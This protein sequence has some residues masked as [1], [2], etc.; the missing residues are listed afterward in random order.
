[1]AE[2]LAIPPETVKVHR[3]HRY[4]KLDI[5]AQPE[6]FSLFLQSLGHAPPPL[7]RPS[8]ATMARHSRSVRTAE[9]RARTLAGAGAA[10]RLQAVPSNTHKRTAR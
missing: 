8:A 7:T 9:R 5:C 1:M 10:P 6:L 2:R 4:A 3:R